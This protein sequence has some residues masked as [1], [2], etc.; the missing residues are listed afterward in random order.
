MIPRILL[1]SLAV[2]NLGCLPEKHDFRPLVSVA[3][4]TAQ[5]SEHVPDPGP[6]PEPNPPGEECIN[7]GGTGE[8]GDTTTVIKCPVCGGDGVMDRLDKMRSEL[9]QAVADT[10]RIERLEAEIAKLSTAVHAS[11][12][13]PTPV[14]EVNDAEALAEQ[15]WEVFERDYAEDFAKLLIDNLKRHRQLAP[16][17][18]PVIEAAP[19]FLEDYARALLISQ[20]LQKPLLITYSSLTCDPCR[21][22]AVTQAGMLEELAKDFVLVRL[23]VQRDPDLFAAEGISTFPTQLVRYGGKTIGPKLV[24]LPN[25]AGYRD[26]VAKRLEEVGRE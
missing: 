21:R 15:L 20:R 16:A 9:L 3:A 25:P 2:F 24:G 19:A 5:A 22:L 6:A 12:C 18:E 1:L 4:G 7:C 8:L 10:T 23:Y 26:W 14:L 13:V 11:S 17:E